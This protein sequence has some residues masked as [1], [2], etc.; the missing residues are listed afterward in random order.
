RRRAVEGRARA[1]ASLSRLCAHARCCGGGESRGP[2][3]A[4]ASAR[5]QAEEALGDGDRGLAARSLPDLCEIHSPPAAAR[6]VDTEP[7]ARDRG[8]LIHGAI[9]DYT[10]RFAETAPADPLGEL[11]KLGEHRFAALSDYPEARAFWW[12]RFER[13]ARWF[14]QWDVQRRG[15]LAALKAEIRGELSFP[16]GASTFTL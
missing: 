3:R 5:R 8:T 9:G 12:P 1:R 15:R 14:V 4:Q 6:P 11:L 13:I 16:A 2:A 10:V 7:G